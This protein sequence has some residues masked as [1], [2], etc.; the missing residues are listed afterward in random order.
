VDSYVTVVRSL[1]PSDFMQRPSGRATK[2]DVRGRLLAFESCMISAC[3]RMQDR[4][5]ES[6]CSCFLVA[7]A[8]CSRADLEPI[9]YSVMDD[10]RR[11]AVEELCSPTPPEKSRQNQ[12]LLFGSLRRW[13]KNNAS[14]LL[15]STPSLPQLRLDTMSY[16]SSASRELV[17][18]VKL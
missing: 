18:Y 14:S 9:E 1:L 13:L 6:Y 7:F 16:P 2:V 4:I 10:A 3:R 8:G 5:E 12:N 17:R 11:G 15:Q